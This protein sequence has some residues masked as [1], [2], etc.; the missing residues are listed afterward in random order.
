M[1]AAPQCR[2]AVARRTS[3]S[4]GSPDENAHNANRQV[5]VKPDPHGPAAAAAAVQPL[6]AHHSDNDHDDEDS[7]VQVIVK[8]EAAAEAVLQDAAPHDADVDMA[9]AA[10]PPPHPDGGD[11]SPEGSDDEDEDDD[12]FDADDVGAAVAELCEPAPEP[13]GVAAPQMPPLPAVELKA[14]RAIELPE[15]AAA[16]QRYIER[17]LTGFSHFLFDVPQVCY[18]V[19]KELGVGPKGPRAKRKLR[20]LAADMTHMGLRVW[21]ELDSR[22]NKDIP[23]DPAAARERVEALAEQVKHVLHVALSK[24]RVQ[25]SKGFL[26]FLRRAMP[27]EIAE[28]VVEV[29]A[30]EGGQ[31]VTEMCALLLPATPC[32]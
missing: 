24:Q 11:V 15:D 2:R 31:D 21:Q 10:P 32:M 14:P 17:A 6:A 1:C 22:L 4:I 3:A 13:V 29:E 8:P 26:G 9:D 5:I 30:E 20:A 28:R 16:A 25:T 7:D 23:A 12:D 18:Y 27:V 19:A